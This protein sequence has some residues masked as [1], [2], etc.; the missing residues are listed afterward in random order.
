MGGNCSQNGGGR[1][2]SPAPVGRPAAGGVLVQPAGQ[3][4]PLQDQ[5]DRAGHRCRVLAT[6]QG[7]E[8]G[9]QRGQLGQGCH[10]GGPG[11]ILAG[12]GASWRT[13]SSSRSV[14]SG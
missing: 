2:S 9:R 4:E 5:L 8:G 13:T 3:V 14:S 11:S 6:C 12:G 7:Q 10:G 1:A